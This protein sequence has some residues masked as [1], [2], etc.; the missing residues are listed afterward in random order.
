MDGLKPWAECILHDHP[1]GPVVE[2]PRSSRAE[3]TPPIN[4]TLVDEEIPARVGKVITNSI[5]MR[6]VLI[7]GVSS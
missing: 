1:A 4:H 7:P 5:G 2:S 6:L 3:W